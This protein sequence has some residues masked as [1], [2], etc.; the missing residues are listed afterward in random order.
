MLKKLFY[1]VF[2]LCV[3]ELIFF[4]KKIYAITKLKGIENFPESYRPYL[5]EL[6]RKYPN[7]EFTALYTGIDWN[8]VIKNEYGNDKNLVPLNYSDEWKCKDVGK[9]NVEI[10]AGWV[11]ASNRAIRYV[12]DPR[13]FLNE[14][15]IFQFEKLIY[16]ENINNELGV[17]KILYGTDFYNKLVSYRD[18]NRKY[19]KYIKKIF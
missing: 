8:E 6:K 1:I 10:D 17:D 4:D 13:N 9:Y 3:I 5:Y 15:R 19:Y 16:D 12:M 2:F 18:S 11:N 7:W 14:V